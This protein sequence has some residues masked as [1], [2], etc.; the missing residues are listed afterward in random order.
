M[1]CPP[2]KNMLPKDA[3]WSNTVKKEVDFL[4]FGKW[5]VVGGSNIVCKGLFV[6]ICV[7]VFCGVIGDPKTGLIGNEVSIAENAIKR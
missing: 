4:S 3:A 2:H 5:L 6:S 1:G 7:D